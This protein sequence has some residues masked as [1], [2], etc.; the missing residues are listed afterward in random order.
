ML[1]ITKF[2]KFTERLM[3]PI[4][5]KLTEIPILIFI[6]VISSKTTSYIN[7]IFQSGR[8]DNLAT[9]MAFV[10]IKAHNLHRLK[11]SAACVP[12]DAL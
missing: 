12:F 9:L 2:V 4:V 5:T 11:T 7:L 6:L 3:L 8:V 1:E 10:S